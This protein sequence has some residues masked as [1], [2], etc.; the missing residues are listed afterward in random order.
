MNTLPHN[1]E[2]EADL[3]RLLQRRKLLLLERDIARKGRQARRELDREQRV[4]SK[5]QAKAAARAALAAE[6][7]AETPSEVEAEP[8]RSGSWLARTFL[9]PLLGKSS[10]PRR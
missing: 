4:L 8:V 9:R 2:L 6:A 5:R 7:A 10:G 3:Q 1:I